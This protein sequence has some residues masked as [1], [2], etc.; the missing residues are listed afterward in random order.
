MPNVAKETIN[1]KSPPGQCINLNRKAYKNIETEKKKRML[2]T[3]F[4]PSL[5]SEMSANKKYNGNKT[6]KGKINRISEPGQCITRNKMA[7]KK[8]AELKM[9]RKFFIS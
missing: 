9:A 7:I 6:P 1:I 5:H 3:L 8:R 4:C 2:T